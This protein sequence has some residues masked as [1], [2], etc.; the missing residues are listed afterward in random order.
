MN[1][2]PKVFAAT[3]QSIQ[4]NILKLIEKGWQIHFQWIPSHCNF[5]PNDTVDLAANLGRLLP[6]VTYRNLELVDLQ[7]LVKCRQTVVWQLLWDVEKQGTF[8]GNIKD[9]LGEWDWCRSA[10]RALDVTMT[11]LRLGKVGLK[12]YL[13]DM[14]QTDS[15]ICTQ[16]TQGVVET[17]EHHLLYCMAYSAERQTLRDK[18]RQEGVHTMNIQTL[19]GASQYSHHTKRKITDYLACFIYT[20]KRFEL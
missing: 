19:L 3:V 9:K 5:G 4:G 18:L 1:R 17:I 2:K 11:R 13:K 7:R 16:C 15:D 8:L 20:C 12:K 10:I 6:N 14:K